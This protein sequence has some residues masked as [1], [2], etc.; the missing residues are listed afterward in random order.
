MRAF[1]GVRNDTREREFE[2][3]YLESYGIVYGYVCSLMSHEADVEDVVSGAFLRAA[4]S[5]GSF[6]PKRAKFS[7]WVT[8]IARNCMASYYRKERPSSALNDVP[9]SFCAIPDSQ[10]ALGD[11]ELVERQRLDTEA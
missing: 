10:D 4:R 3:L 11:E 1:R 2:R 5:F 6:D 9:E 7:I 8:A